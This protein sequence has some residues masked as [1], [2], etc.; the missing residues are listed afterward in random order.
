VT[1]PDPLDAAA[2]DA[3]A[4]RAL[5]ELQQ[6]SFE[7]ANAA[8]R[9]SYPPER[10]MSGEQ[11]VRYLDA[12]R[13]AVVATTR[14]DGRPHAALSGYLRVGSKLWLPTVAGSARASNLAR[15]P[16]LSIVVSDGAGPDHAAVI[17]EATAELVRRDA[18]PVEVLA[19]YAARGEPAPDWAD[20]FVAATPTK[21]LSY[22][23]ATRE[24]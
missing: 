17:I 12:P 14:K 22:V 8:T 7:R 5:G 24:V 18:L 13:Y 3:P 1:D 2:P 20:V 10:R 4:A 6:A 23:R 9:S 16:A 21:L 19:A 11:L 15:Q